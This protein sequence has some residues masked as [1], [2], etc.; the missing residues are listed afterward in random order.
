MHR[1]YMPISA[2][3]NVK[4]MN[5]VSCLATNQAIVRTTMLFGF[6]GFTLY[7]FC[8]PTRTMSILSTYTCDPNFMNFMDLKPFTK[9]KTLKSA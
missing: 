3:Y 9:I 5:S 7:M 1:L 4:S 2:M 6:N 8:V